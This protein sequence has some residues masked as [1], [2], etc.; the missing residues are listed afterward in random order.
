M[1][2]VVKDISPKKVRNYTAVDK[3][4]DKIRVASDQ[5]DKVMSY[6]DDN[7]GEP[8]VGGPDLQ[9]FEV[10]RRRWVLCF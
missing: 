5:M 4:S 9:I 1:P 3:A 7:F 6:V 10:V 8:H 2:G